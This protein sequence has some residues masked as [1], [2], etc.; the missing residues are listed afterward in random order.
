MYSY[1]SYIYINFTKI[2]DFFYFIY[3]QERRR[4][5]ANK[6]AG[7]ESPDEV[8]SIITDGMDQNKTNYRVPKSSQ[9]LWNLRTHLTGALVH[10]TG[11]FCFLDFLQWS[12]DTNLTLTCLLLT[13]KEIDTVRVLPKKLLIQ[14]DNCVRE[15]KNK[16]VLGFLSLLVEKNIYTEVSNKLLTCAYN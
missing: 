8:L 13:L 6:Q 3:R 2:P 12:H 10:G 11:S 5:Y 15:N 9:N 4:Y 16:Y 7:I 14:M 1:L